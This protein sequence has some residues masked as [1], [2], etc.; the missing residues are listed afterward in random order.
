MDVWWNVCGC[1]VRGHV[2]LYECAKEQQLY[3]GWSVWEEVYEY[4][5]EFAFGASLMWYSSVLPYIM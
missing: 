5:E 4:V 2:T 3:A 1:G